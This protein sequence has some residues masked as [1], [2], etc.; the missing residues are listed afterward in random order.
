MQCRDSVTVWGPL[1]DPRTPS[2]NDTRFD[3]YRPKITAGI[4]TNIGIWSRTAI[5]IL[6][7]ARALEILTRE[8]SR[9]GFEMHRRSVHQSR[10]RSHRFFYC[11]RYNFYF[12]LLTKWAS[13]MQHLLSA[14]VETTLAVCG[15]TPVAARDWMQSRPSALK[16]SKFQSRNY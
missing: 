3:S 14:R 11:Q 1:G 6:I 8:Q 12:L 4:N 10:P 15:G 13:N 7:P 16:S 2:L 9:A 5:A